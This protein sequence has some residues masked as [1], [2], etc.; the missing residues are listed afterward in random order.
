MKWINLQ[1]SSDY[2]LKYYR[3]DYYGMSTFS[4]QVI[5]GTLMTHRKIWLKLK[6]IYICMYKILISL[7]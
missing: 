5:F 6:N 4:K 2:L 3:N 7:S 1:T